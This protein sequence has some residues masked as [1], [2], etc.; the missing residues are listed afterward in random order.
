VSPFRIEI[1]TRCI[2][3]M[4][5]LLANAAA[6]AHWPRV[7]RTARHERRLAV[8]GGGPLVI[9]D[10]DEL[11]AWDG[12]IWAINH[13]AKWLNDQGV[14]ATLYSID[15]MPMRTEAPDALLANVC[16]PDLVKSFAGRLRMFDMA[17]TH[18]DG[19]DGG[20]PG[21]GITSAIRAPALAFYMGYLDVSLFGCE[22]SFGETDHVDRNE[23]EDMQLIVRA[24]GADYRTTP[25]F[26]AQCEQLSTLFRTLT[27]AF[28][29]RSGGLLKAMIENPDSWEVVAVSAALKTHLEAVNGPCGMYEEPY[30]PAA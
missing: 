30:R 6:N 17:E 28:H 20:L 23:D 2:A 4:D 14:R 15:P 19:I 7:Y 26:L 29:N 5:A 11:R 21:G 13:T 9:H 25:G 27:A 24:G 12:D 10:L 18:P 22:G 3:S 16:D 1:K 8:V